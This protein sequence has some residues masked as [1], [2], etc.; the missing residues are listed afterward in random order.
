MTPFPHATPGLLAGAPVPPAGAGLSLHLASDLDGTWLPAAGREGD[1]RAL[2]A[3]LGRHPGVVLTFATGRTLESAL[4]VLAGRVEVLPRF[5]VTDV[6]TAIFERQS[7]GRWVEL[8]AYAQWVEERWDLEAVRGALLGALPAGVIQQSGVLPRRRLAL[9][10]QGGCGLG[11]A[12]EALALRLR[13]QGVEADL[14]A[15]SER[16]LDVLPR[17]VHKGAAIGYLQNCMGLPRP[18]VAC[19][20]SEN[21]LE[22]LQGADLPVLMVRNSLTAKAQATLGAGLCRAQEPGPLGILHALAGL[23]PP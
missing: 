9:E 5:L 8:G 20:D 13:A 12:A 18:L 19:G 11:P 15:S 6:G 10:V 17:G 3:F 2:E 7:K 23:V 14:L 22:M 1:L 21:D 16:C 4:A